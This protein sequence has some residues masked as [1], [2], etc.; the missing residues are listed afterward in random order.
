MNQSVLLV[1]ILHLRLNA[2]VMGGGDGKKIFANLI[3]E[4]AGEEYEVPVTGRARLK[5]SVPRPR[6]QPRSRV[7]RVCGERNL[8]YGAGGETLS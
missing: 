3:L 7:L 1:F 5:M 8:N 6:R 2:L 4:L